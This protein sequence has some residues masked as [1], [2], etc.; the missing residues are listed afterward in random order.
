M[1]NEQER[2]QSTGTT[3]AL[4]AEMLAQQKLTNAL[5]QRVADAVAFTGVALRLPT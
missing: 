4:L 5:L 2:D 1:E 3:N